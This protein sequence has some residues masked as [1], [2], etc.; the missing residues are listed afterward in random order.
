MIFEKTRR[1]ALLAMLAGGLTLAGPAHATGAIECGDPSSSTSVNILL[2]AGPVPNVLSVA[3]KAGGNRFTT[4][5]GQPGEQLS[6]AQAYDDGE[7]VRIDLVDMQA[8]KRV[9]A[10]RILRADGEADPF[11]IGYVEI[12]G[13]D[14]IGVT[15]EG[16]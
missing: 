15:C 12:N 14:P 13:H 9:A 1:L 7:I 10:V 6:I 3:I 8:Q 2:G 11:Q 4:V 16:P 5:P